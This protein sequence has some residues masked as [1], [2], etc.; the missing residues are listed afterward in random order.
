MA[1]IK[2]HIT[3]SFMLSSP[4]VP[5]VGACLKLFVIAIDKIIRL[6]IILRASDF[7]ILRRSPLSNN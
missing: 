4:K 5:S 3:Y 6:S 1:W 7:L 2:L